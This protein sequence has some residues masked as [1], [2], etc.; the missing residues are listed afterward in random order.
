MNFFNFILINFLFFSNI[1]TIYSFKNNN[2][3]VKCKKPSN[4]ILYSKKNQFNKINELC[5][6]S[7]TNNV[8]PTLFLSLSGGL[9]M[10]PSLK[11]FQSSQF[12]S[13]N[14]ITIMIMT[15]SMVVNDICDIKL[16]KINNPTRPLVSGSITKNEALLYGLLLFTLIE[17]LSFNFLPSNLQLLT[18]LSIFGITIYTPILKKIPLIKNIFCASLV[19]FTLFYSGMSIKFTDY[20]IDLLFIAIRYIFIGSLSIELLLDILDIDG[21]S[22]NNINTVPVI[23]GKEKTINLLNILL[24]FNTLNILSLIKIYDNFIC[25][26]PVLFLV[27]YL[28]DFNKIKKNNYEKNFIKKTIK[29]T[30]IPMCL[31][32]ITFCL[33]SYFNY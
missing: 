3:V 31:M 23:F 16:D 30:T 20:N 32:L 22:K 18:N 33:I 8:I 15:L 19:S 13:S 10:K 27:P 17:I 26:I 25:G 21:D 1:I 6:L 14:L 29:N 4:L 11:L 7:R 24:L 9:I 5:K 2:F 12:I 28:F